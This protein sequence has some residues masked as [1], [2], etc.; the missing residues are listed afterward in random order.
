[1]LSFSFS[2]FL[3]SNLL[4]KKTGLLCQI[5]CTAGPVIK[6]RGENRKPLYN[7][8][9][10]N[11]TIKGPKKTPYEGYLFKFEITYTNDYPRVPPTVKCITDIYHMNIS[12]TGDVC[13][14][15]IHDMPQKGEKHIWN[16]AGDINTVLLSIFVI[17]GRPNP[18]NPYRSDLA[19]IYIKNAKIN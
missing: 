18:D 15:S 8:L 7:M 6:S 10:W 4:L 14:G 12:T 17:L 3:L 16:D 13:V 19:E 5:G 11:A 1:M 2:F 9:K